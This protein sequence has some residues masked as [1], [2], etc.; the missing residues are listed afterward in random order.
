MLIDLLHLGQTSCGP[1][2]L[3]SRATLS[4][5]IP[6]PNLLAGQVLYIEPFGAPR[7]SESICGLGL[8][9]THP[10]LPGY[11]RKLCSAVQHD[12]RVGDLASGIAPLVVFTVSCRLWLR[13]DSQAGWP[14]VRYRGLLP[15]SLCHR[16]F[17]IDFSV[18]QSAAAGRELSL[19][20]RGL[21]IRL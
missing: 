7:L 19:P 5:A 11:T 1:S 16:T 6:L 4:E 21:R 17:P 10:E 9:N 15:D 14:R 13:V 18:A 3:T 2:T 12:K 8:S 20:S